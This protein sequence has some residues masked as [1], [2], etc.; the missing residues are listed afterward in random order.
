MRCRNCG[1]RSAAASV[2]EL[3]KEKECAL[4]GCYRVL[5]SHYKIMESGFVAVI[6]RLKSSLVCFCP[7][8]E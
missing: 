3:K 1:R 4:G 7:S 8:S 6:T 5:R 2:R